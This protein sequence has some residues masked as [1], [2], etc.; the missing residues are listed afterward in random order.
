M[1]TYT[2]ERSFSI[3]NLTEQCLDLI[4]YSNMTS[5]KQISGLLLVLAS[6]CSCITDKSPLSV[7]VILPAVE[8]HA[9]LNGSL[10]YWD[11]NDTLSSATQAASEIN[12]CPG[13]LD[14]FSIEL[15]PIQASNT[16]PYKAL[17][18]FYQHLVVKD[19]VI[20]IGMVGVID[21]KLGQVLLPVASHPGIDLVSLVDPVVPLNRKYP[22][23]FTP[24]TSLAYHM[25][26]V[27]HILNDL[28][29][30]RIGLVYNS[31]YDDP[32]Y[33]RAARTFIHLVKQVDATID[34]IHIDL[35][36]NFTHTT[37][38][39]LEKTE[40]LVFL[41]LL[42]LSVST[43]LISIIQTRGL[44]YVWIL[45][46][47][48]S[49]N[50]LQQLSAVNLNHT[51]IIQNTASNHTPNTTAFD[52]LPMCADTTKASSDFVYRSVWDLSLALNSSQQVLKLKHSA[53]NHSRYKSKLKTSASLRNNCEDIQLSIYSNYNQIVGYFNPF[54]N[55]FSINVTFNI[56]GL[57]PNVTYTYIFS[58]PSLI[59]FTT[60]VTGICYLFTT[61]VL[62]L[63]IYYRNQPEIKATSV[64]LSLC[65][66]LGCYFILSGALNHF[67]ANGERLKSRAR[68][69]FA[70]N[71]IKYFVSL[72]VDLLI[73]TLLAK[74]L[75]IWRIFTLYG[76]T[77]KV[78]TDP[79]LL[80]F[81]GIVIAVKVVLLA[82]WTIV[83]PYT[84]TDKEKL[85]HEDGFGSTYEILQ[86]CE[87]EY[88]YIWLV[89]V[90][91]YSTVI[92]LVLIGASW[93]TRKVKRENFKDTKKITIVVTSL[94]F[95]A[96]LCGAL[97]GILRLI[98][99]S[100]ASKLV[101]GLAYCMIAL[102]SEVLLFL[103]KI[104]P[105]LL[106]QF[107]LPT[108][109]VRMKQHTQSSLS[110]FGTKPV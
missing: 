40:A 67:I 48:Y 93:K 7:V 54:T 8:D 27:V 63:F 4:Q 84:K 83:D 21:K 60:A 30:N 43:Q 94:I 62:L 13:V 41:C 75:R 12:N 6:V 110:S 101:I 91:G 78:W 29:W 96:L 104:L 19:D 107:K 15:I 55:N 81:I 49:N 61:I 106:R 16:D 34:V 26:A 22:H 100:I 45:V 56:P 79:S 82:I 80:G 31:T 105:A 95:I 25:E 32:V 68:R 11:H 24:Y 64:W 76:R 1:N 90:Y 51:L 35:T 99:G 74:V 44:N 58:P 36:S 85:V 65:M 89:L 28:Q 10:L 102:L 70:C 87:S 98:G 59:Y 5:Q 109:D 92:G 39:H 9:A 73:T 66:F 38:D 47:L 97:W 2:L 108:S 3:A 20:K 86:L 50:H 17:T 103:P 71:I 72:G 57:G 69:V 88:Y 23:T 46:T 53:I 18:Q 77:G 33:L 52:Q 42:P 37:G 14:N